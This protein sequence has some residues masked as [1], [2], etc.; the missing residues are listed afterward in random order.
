METWRKVWRDGLAP[1][2]S[3]EALEALGLALARDDPRLI[4][5]ATTCPPPSEVFHDADVEGACALGYCGWKGEGLPTVGQVE[6][7]FIRTCLA[8]DDALGEPAACRHFLN[9][10]DETP[11]LTLRRLLLAEVERALEDRR[12]LAA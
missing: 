6:A 5:H 12:I 2:L 10:F 11:R 8:A 7:F 9:W 3:M 4:Q 1:L